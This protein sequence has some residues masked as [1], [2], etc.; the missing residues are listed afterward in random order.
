MR[1]SYIRLIR[2]EVSLVVVERIQ[3]ILFR[4]YPIRPLK[5]KTTCVKKRPRSFN[6]QRGKD[7]FT[8]NDCTVTSN[9]LSSMSLLILY[10]TFM[11]SWSLSNFSHWAGD[12]SPMNSGLP[13][14]SGGVEA[15][16][17]V[18]LPFN[19]LNS[20]S[21]DILS[22]GFWNFNATSISFRHLAVS[23]SFWKSKKNSLY[24]LVCINIKFHH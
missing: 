10:S 6:N 19:F 1:E 17:S 12:S 15:M 16:I 23:L 18:S 8:R 22:G 21:A 13:T 11:S 20:I 2:H 24:Y 9:R 14:S 7:R 5:R 4:F 3:L